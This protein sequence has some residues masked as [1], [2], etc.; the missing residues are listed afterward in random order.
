MIKFS[1]N[2]SLLQHNT[3]G[4]DVKADVFV[5]YTHEDDLPLIF[6]DERVKG[7]KYMHI[8]QGSN[9]LFTKDYDGVIMHSRIKGIKI[10]SQ[11][12]DTVLVE[13]AAGET[14]DDVC[15]WC[16][17]HGYHGVENLSAIPGDVGAAAV[18][19]IGAYGV[20]F[21]DVVIAV[22]VYDIEQN[23]H[24]IISAE[25]CAYG[26]RTSIFK[27]EQYRNRF[28]VTGVLLQLHRKA[29]F[30][31]E[32]GNIKAAL[33]ERGYSLSQLNEKRMGK[34]QPMTGK[35]ITLH[36]LRETIVSIRMS[37]LPDPKHIGNAGSFF[38][39]P[40]I[41]RLKYSA[42]LT[43]WPDMPMYE[44][45]AEH[46]KVPAGWLIEHSGG[47]SRHVGNASVYE[48][49]CLVLVNNGQAKPADVVRL[50]ETIIE[51]VSDRFDISIQPE[52]III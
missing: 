26:Y 16:V 33:L 20:E 49:Q 18:Q 48:H 45:D 30:N 21:A 6:A 14:W 1:F 8:G 4:F 29:A 39:N 47:K 43:Q 50:A 52:V 36:T 11:T 44:V 40:I 35:T 31:I 19:N 28:V 42:L 3:F 5:E 7:K 51:A 2:A 32:Y 38:K 9:L 15:L 10:A 24:V 12:D 41:T 37:K 46:V 13:C 22:A 17:N 25:D 23:R 27:H 34:R